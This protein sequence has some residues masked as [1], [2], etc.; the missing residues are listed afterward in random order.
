LLV[1]LVVVSAATV[2]LFSAGLAGA[3]TTNVHCT[4]SVADQATLQAAIN[5]GGTVN[6]FGTCLGDWTIN[7]DVTL[8]AGA[9]GATLD[10][11]AAGS[12]LTVPDNRRLT[13]RSL[14][15][16]N[17]SA[18]SGGGIKMV[19][20]NSYATLNSSTV[21]AN[22]A[23]N[24][25]G[26]DA[27]CGVLTL[28]ASTV[29]TNTA[30]FGGGI[31]GS[32]CDCELFNS[33]VDGN[34]NGMFGVGGGISV[35]GGSYLKLTGST[36]SNNQGAYEGGGI[37]ISESV[38]QATASTITGNR[39]TQLSVTYGGGG[40]WMADSQV[41]LDSTR[42]SWNTS[43]DFG[44]GIA[45]YGHSQQQQGLTV[46]NSTI[47]HN[48]AAFSGGGIYSKASFGPASV[49]LDHST[50]SFNKVTNG[51]GGGISNYGDCGHTASILAT[52]S[53]FGGNLALSGQGG[54]IYNS[55]G[56]CAGGD[57]ALVT[58]SRTLV[59]QI[60]NSVNPNQASYGGGIFN[61]PG[62]GAS[63]VSIQPGTHVVHNK[64]SVTG[65]GL[66][67]CSTA[68]YSLLPGATVFLNQPNN[69]VNAAVCPA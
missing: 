28:T 29:K 2:L 66:F 54:A 18:S 12:V 51:D 14:K 26:I 61:E 25:G 62:D 36:V 45:Y 59:G 35:G 9:P 23:S 53:A 3:T 27:G 34:T 47:D 65:G 40:I 67:N 17:G 48:R 37:L 1:L 16:T 22:T 31:S 60:G 24:G 6:V 68:T 8:Q 42:V 13:T 32:G 43:A 20:C 39:T 69:I 38:L 15:I 50:V 7:S 21:W 63:D 10:G 33:T 41:S 5:A 44:G 19:G 30:P 57:V 58:L 46:T 11:N 49:S 56:N 64:A 52:D 55:N 4:D